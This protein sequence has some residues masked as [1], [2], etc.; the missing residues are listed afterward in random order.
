MG[1]KGKGYSAPFPLPMITWRMLGAYL[2]LPAG[3]L[4]WQAVPREG[5]L[6]LICWFHVCV[7]RDAG[8]EGGEDGLAG[9]GDGGG[10]GKG[11]GKRVK[12]GKDNGGMKEM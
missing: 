5:V 4:K 1:G 7:L 9:G 11:E 10:P 8:R 3:A 6:T 12:G 2:F